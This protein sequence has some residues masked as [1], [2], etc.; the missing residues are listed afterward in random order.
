MLNAFSVDLEDFYHGNGLGLTLADWPRFPSRVSIGT[1]RLLELLDRHQTRATFFVL[2][3]IA[4]KEPGLIRE[5]VAAGHEIACHTHSHRMLSEY[6]PH[7]FKVELKHSLCL[8][9]EISGQPVIGF[10]APT[11]S[12]NETTR[13]VL[14]MLRNEGIV[15]DAS[16]LPMQSRLLT[17]GWPE[18][19]SEPHPL[20]EGLIECPITVVR[21]GPICYPVGV[22]AALR[23]TPLSITMAL[24]RRSQGRANA[25]VVLNIHPSDLDPEQPRLPLGFA[26]RQLKY[27][28]M[29]KLP[30]KIEALFSAFPFGRIDDLLRSIGLLS[31]E[32]T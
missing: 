11:W 13:W 6:T 24:L 5:I 9:R 18:A 17:C 22:A 14:P 31:G 10:R 7:E 32:V 25:P 16:A 20:L 8:L 27:R 2:S 29:S 1:R 30:G 4:G 19:R 26:M 3:W 12:L 15:Y 28:G 21:F 23:M